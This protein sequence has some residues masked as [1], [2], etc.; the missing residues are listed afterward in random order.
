MTKILLVDDIRNFLDLEISFLKRADC[1]IFTASTGAEALK[2]AKQEKPDIILLD[3][4]MPEMGGIETTRI[5]KAD[6][7]LKKIPVIIVTSTNKRDESLKAGADDFV[8]KPINERGL[9]NEIKK[10]ISIKEREEERVPIGLEVK[11]RYMGIDR[12]N[13]SRDISSKGIF[14]ITEKPVPIGVELELEFDLPE[15]GKS[16]RFKIKAAVVREERE[17]REGRI[18]TGMGLEFRDFSEEKD[19][20]IS[21]F[22]SRQ[23]K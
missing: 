16:G 15:D 1:R 3:L 11:Y 7:E 20:K 9:L 21:Q 23:M 17:E 5:L 18:I 2:L 22:I 8:Q 10:F 19:R 13:Y 14:L 12:V 4:V 6:P